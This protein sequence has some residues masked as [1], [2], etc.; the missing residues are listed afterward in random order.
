MELLQRLQDIEI[1]LD[2]I[3]LI[4]NGPRTVDLDVLMYNDE[5]IDTDRLI[6]PHPRMMEREFVVRPL[7]E[8]V[9]LHTAGKHWKCLTLTALPLIP[10]VHL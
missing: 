2:R 3:K 10:Y 4:Q 5:V 6:V 1:E 9:S 7:N 8:Y